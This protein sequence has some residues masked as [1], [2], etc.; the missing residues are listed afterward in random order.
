MWPHRAVR[1]CGGAKCVL[2]QGWGFRYEL[3]RNA[4]GRCAPVHRNIRCPTQP[5]KR[6]RWEGTW[7]LAIQSSWPAADGEEMSDVGATGEESRLA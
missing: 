2:Q 5:G 1:V 4:S 3:A 6:R 7:E